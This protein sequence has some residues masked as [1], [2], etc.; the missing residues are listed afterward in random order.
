MSS[1][2]MVVVCGVAGVLV[3][4][5]G[6]QDR[7]ELL[8]T[9][10]LE[11]GA[12][13][14]VFVD[15]TAEQVAQRIAMVSGRNY[16][17]FGFNTPE[18]H[19]VLPAV[20][21]SVYAETDF[22]RPTLLDADGNQVPYEPERGIYDHETFHD[23]LRFTPV[24]GDEP[25]AY[26]RAVGSVTVR[27][28]LRIHTLRARAGEPPTEGLDV[29]IDGPYVTRRGRSGDTGP[30][31]EA[32]PFTGIE[33]FR[34]LDADGNRLERAPSG[35]F[36]MA[37]G[38]V[39]EVVAYWGEVAAVELDVA[40]EWA[41]YRVDFELPSVPPLPDERAGV[42]PPDGDENPPTP[43]AVVEVEAVVETP[44]D[45]VGAA[46]GVTP[47]EAKARLAELGFPNPSGEYMVMSAVQGDRDALE[48]FLA[49]GYPID[50][51][52]P[53][54]RTALV[55]ALMYGRFDL[56]RFLVEAGA[57]VNIADANNAT[58]L[59]YAATNC[60]ATDLVRA[61]LD[62]GAD[63]TQAT[64]GGTTALQMAGAM[65]CADNEALIRSAL[66]G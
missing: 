36:S 42:A 1:I 41:T 20:D 11:Q 23:E 45:A 35:Q 56:A 24:E 39:T 7:A 53:D 63:P 25:V 22:G 21:N 34:A 52:T 14:P 3:S 49:A 33:A 60:N 38:V 15:L 57:D 30:E 55:S 9:P 27:Y 5:A 50:F 44:G 37:D 58:P 8:A 6:A 65:G 31:L 26:A 54:G 48:M 61:L 29:T 28:P 18:I 64:A 16:A 59:F 10:K 46:L 13:Q 66:G 2:R 43:G 4:A 40:D 19:V 12:R 47:D 51:V 32:A 17:W 62:A